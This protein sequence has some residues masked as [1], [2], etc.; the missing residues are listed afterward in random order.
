MAN[1]RLQRLKDAGMVF[2]DPPSP[3]VIRRIDA[4]SDDEF[5]SLLAITSTLST[6]QTGPTIEY[7]NG[8]FQLRSGG[9]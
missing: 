1:G 8:G 2:E 3:D 9:E 7:L 5:A 4:L 6:P